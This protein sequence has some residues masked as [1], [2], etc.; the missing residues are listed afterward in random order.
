MSNLNDI[1]YLNSRKETLLKWI[2]MMPIS[3]KTC[4]KNILCVNSGDGTLDKQV[5]EELQNI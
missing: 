3:H 2:K 5:I 1:H 4:I